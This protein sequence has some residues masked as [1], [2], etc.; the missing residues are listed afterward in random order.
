MLTSYLEVSLLGGLAARLE[1]SVDAGPVGTQR[2][3]FL[4]PCWHSQTCTELAKAAKIS[5]NYSHLYEH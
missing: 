4:S 3:S 2:S 1:V 5:Y